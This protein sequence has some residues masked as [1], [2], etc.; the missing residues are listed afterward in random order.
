MTTPPKISVVVP[1]FNEEKYIKPCIESLKNQ[2]FKDFEVIAI[3]KS[4]DSTPQLCQQ[5]GWKIVA[6]KTPGISAARAE[7][8]AATK[9]DIIASTNADTKVNSDWLTKIYEGFADPEVV[10]VYGPVRFIEEHTAFY[11][12]MNQLGLFLYKLSHTLKSDHPSGE[13]FAVRRSAYN[14]IGGFNI[15]LPT[16]EDVDLCY[17]IS[18]VGKMLFLPD[19]IAY[20]SN[21][22]LAKQKL[23]F[24]THHIVN[25]LRLRFFGSASSDFEPIR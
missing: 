6:Q 12:F 9:A 23:H 25:Y 4:T 21:R 2:D 11:R 7:G 24:F 22:R 1:T 10:C 18:K 20:T 17:R 8:F 3:D 19:L 16:A 13:N 5:A 15:K 14:Q